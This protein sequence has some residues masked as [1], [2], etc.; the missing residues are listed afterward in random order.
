[1]LSKEEK[2]KFAEY[3]RHVSNK[4]RSLA[5]SVFRAAGSISEISKRERLKASAYSIVAIDL[6]SD[7]KD[8]SSETLSN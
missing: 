7:T 5:D 4:S 3:C 1:M 8:D 6:E 2:L